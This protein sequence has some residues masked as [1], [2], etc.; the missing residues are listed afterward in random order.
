MLEISKDLAKAYLLKEKFYEFMDA[1]DS[2]K[3]KEKLKQFFLFESVSGL[4]EFKP[5][6]TM[7][8]NWEKYILN[9]FDCKYSN[10][11]TEGCNNS[12]KVIKRTGYGYRNFDNFRTRILMV[13]N[14]AS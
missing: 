13:L 1:K 9:A 6:I 10:G 5:C 7:L 14:K 11:F 2:I 8:T 4:D 3:A 12:I